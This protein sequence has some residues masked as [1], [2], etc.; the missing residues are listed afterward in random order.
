MDI[1][2]KIAT[3]CDGRGGGRPNFAQGG[4][5]NPANLDKVLAEI[6]SELTK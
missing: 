4:A 2:N 6:K 3:A 1:V 5:K